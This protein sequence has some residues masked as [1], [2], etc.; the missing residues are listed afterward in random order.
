MAKILPLHPGDEFIRGIM[1][2]CADHHDLNDDTSRRAF[3][4]AMVDN[5]A[6]I[7]DTDTRGWFAD[8]IV[9]VVSH[10]YTSPDS[11]ITRD[12]ILGAANARLTW[13][14]N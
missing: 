14:R 5:A 2:S 3:M 8:L 13:G 10:R 1:E 7:E 11:R 4:S 6:L 12:A 9:Q